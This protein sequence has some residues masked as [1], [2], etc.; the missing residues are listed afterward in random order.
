MLFMD[1]SKEILLW[2]G[3][4]DSYPENTETYK[5]YFELISENIPDAKTLRYCLKRH[6]DNQNK[7]FPKP[8]ELNNYAKEISK[9]I[10]QNKVNSNP[11]LSEIQRLKASLQWQNDV[12][13]ANKDT[14]LID[15][16]RYDIH[17]T[18]K[19]LKEMESKIHNV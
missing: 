7:F 18:E 8:F 16:L 1:F 12:F 6:H 19:K 9:E 11:V 14:S 4:F 13:I 5:L 15:R 3:I 17:E 10:I 2:Q